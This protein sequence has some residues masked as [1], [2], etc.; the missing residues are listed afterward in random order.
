MLLN[1]PQKCAAPAI[2]TGGNGK[3]WLG[4]AGSLNSGAVTSRIQDAVCRPPLLPKPKHRV[5]VSLL[6]PL[7]QQVMTGSISRLGRGPLELNH[8]CDCVLLACIVHTTLILAPV[9]CATHYSFNLDTHQSS[10]FQVTNAMISV[11]IRILCLHFFSFILE[12]CVLSCHTLI[13][14]LVIFPCV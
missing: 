8:K 6:R 7:V 10:E 1:A 2:V 9:E 11:R 5:R 3:Q 12:V 13:Q 14:F 4:A